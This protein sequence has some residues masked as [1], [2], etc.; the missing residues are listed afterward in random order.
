M[1]ARRHLPTSLLLGLSLAAC[2]AP[3]S[4]SGGSPRPSPASTSSRPSPSPTGPAPQASPSPAPAL[5]LPLRLGLALPT[6]VV[7]AAASARLRGEGGLV[8]PPASSL[9]ALQDGRIVS[10]NAGSVVS[11]NSGSL[12]SDQGAAWRLPSKASLGA[13]FG[14]L[15]S[16]PLEAIYDPRTELWFFLALIDLTDQILQGY[17]QAQP[18]LGAWQRFRCQQARLLPPP[19]G[20]EIF[21]L[22]TAQVEQALQGLPM[23]GHLAQEGEGLHLRVV[24]LPQEGASVA[25]ARPLAELSTGPDGSA[26]AHF[27]LFPILLEA[28]GLKAASTRMLKGADGGLS[29]ESG[30]DFSPPAE[31]GPLAKAINGERLLFAIRRRVVVPAP[32]PESASLRVLRAELKEENGVARGLN[33]SAFGFAP[34]GRPDV[35]LASYHRVSEGGASGALAPFVWRDLEHN[36]F[37]GDGPV[38][39]RYLLPS[40]EATASPPAGLAALLPAFSPALDA[41]IPALPEPGQAVS[42]D[43][44]LRIPALPA[45]LLQAPGGP[46]L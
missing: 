14:L 6:S 3:A 1:S 7:G 43:A 26:I 24:L 4:P 15:Q 18:R 11:N 20:A 33:L 25:E 35:G 17:V 28:F 31:R 27:Q 29:G 46:S 40:G 21:A 22:A 8:A 12:V 23:A 30:E 39:P 16:K 38:V 10:N 45:A 9:T 37:P 13:G 32:G 19:A 42:E 5:R 2:Q 36:S 41:E 44:A 34:A